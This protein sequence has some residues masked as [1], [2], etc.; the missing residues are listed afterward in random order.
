MACF[1][2][3]ILKNFKSKMEKIPTKKKVQQK[4]FRFFLDLINVK[5]SHNFYV[6]VSKPCLFVLGCLWQYNFTE[7]SNCVVFIF[8]HGSSMGAAY[9]WMWLIHGMFTVIIVINQARV[10]K[11]NNNNKNT[12]CIK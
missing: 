6:S 8:F 1:K 10:S 5:E 4:T 2:V 9:L 3:I 12:P 11:V 7:T